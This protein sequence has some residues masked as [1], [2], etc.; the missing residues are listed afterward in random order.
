MHQAVCAL[1]G[2]GCVL[3]MGDAARSKDAREKA[4]VQGR[5]GCRARAYGA[6]SRWRYAASVEVATCRRIDSLQV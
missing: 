2:L 4:A 5:L 6:H 1:D 3:L